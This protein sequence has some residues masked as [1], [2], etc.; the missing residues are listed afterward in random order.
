MIWVQRRMSAKLSFRGL[1]S[2][3]NFRTHHRPYPQTKN[4]CWP[5]ESK[6]TCN[7]PRKFVS[8]SQ[9]TKRIRRRVLCVL[10]TLRISFV[11]CRFTASQL[12]LDIEQKVEAGLGLDVIG[13]EQP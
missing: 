2:V 13:S 5:T 6:R 11:V 1:V 10:G 7:L 12:G 4:T 3:P 9:A 8:A